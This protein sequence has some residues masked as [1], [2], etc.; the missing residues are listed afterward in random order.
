MMDFFLQSHCERLRSWYVCASER[1]GSKY[2]NVLQNIHLAHREHAQHLQQDA[3][4]YYSLVTTGG[5]PSFMRSQHMHAVVNVPPAGGA[6]PPIGGTY[7]STWNSLGAEG[8][9]FA[10][11]AARR[12]VSVLHWLYWSIFCVSRV[13][14][15]LNDRK[16]L[17]LIICC[18]H[19]HNKY[20]L[21]KS[22]SIIR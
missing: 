19:I 20:R 2:G 12:M 18:R 21:I 14:A 8:Q 15:D 3:L 4:D 9:S 11:T 6:Q 7:S 16:V 1:A 5:H 10:E 13:S 17:M 22:I